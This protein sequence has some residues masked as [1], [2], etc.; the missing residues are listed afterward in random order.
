MVFCRVVIF[1]VVALAV[2]A[3]VD[4]VVVVVGGGGGGGGVKFVTVV[5]VECVHGWGFCSWLWVPQNRYF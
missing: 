4:G 5:G 3:N 2:V 1:V